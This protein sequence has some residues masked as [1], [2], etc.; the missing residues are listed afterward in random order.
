V[1]GGGQT[2]GEFGP[3]GRVNFQNSRL[4]SGFFGGGAGPQ[5]RFNQNKTPFRPPK[6]GDPP[7]FGIFSPPGASGGSNALK[8]KTGLFVR[9]FSKTF[10]GRGP[11]K[12]LQP[13]GGRG[14][15]GGLPKGFLGGRGGD[16]PNGGAGEG[17]GGAGPRFFGG[18]WG[19][20]DE[21]APR[22]PPRGGKTPT[23]ETGGM[24]A[25]G[26]TTGASG[27]KIGGAHGGPQGTPD[28]FPRR[29]EKKRTAPGITKPV[30]FQP[31]GPKFP[32]SG[33]GPNLW[34]GAAACGVGMG[35]GERGAAETSRSGQK[36]PRPPL[37]A[38]GQNGGGGGPGDV[39]LAN[40]T[41]GNLGL[42]FPPRGR[43]GAGGRGAEAVASGGTGT[44]W[45]P[46]SFFPQ[47]RGPFA[48]PVGGGGSRRGGGRGGKRGQVWGQRGGFLAPAAPAGWGNWGGG[49]NGGPGWE[50]KKNPMSGGGCGGG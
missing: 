40:Y 18:V 7:R 19:G 14:D 6:T 49:Q 45:D 38:G 20:E 21:R 29:G 37:Y 39:F 25:G 42:F 47:Q 23:G 9:G 13:P 36:T 2:Q 48:G 33:P 28:F 16:G 3:K 46:R 35:R 24:A 32:G 43:G 12:P 4:N 17:Q 1:G 15:R 22:A 50:R 5:P 34:P 31:R 30:K 41:G 44:H 26:H 8:R 27:K 10:L 11:P